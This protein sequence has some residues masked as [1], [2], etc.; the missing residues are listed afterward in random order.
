MHRP[1]PHPYV[2]IEPFVLPLRENAPYGTPPKSTAPGEREHSS[3]FIKFRDDAGYN[4]LKELTGFNKWYETDAVLNPSKGLLRDPYNKKYVRDQD[5]GEATL[6]L[7]YKRWVNYEELQRV[8]QKAD[9]FFFED[10]PGP[11]AQMMIPLT[12]PR[13]LLPTSPISKMVTKME[14]KNQVDLPFSLSPEQK[15]RV[16]EETTKA[17]IPRLKSDQEVMSYLETK[18]GELYDHEN[19]D[20]EYLTHLNKVDQRQPN[21]ELFTERHMTAQ[22]RRAEFWRKYLELFTYVD[23]LHTTMVRCTRAIGRVGSYA[24]LVIMGNGHGIFTYGRGKAPEREQSIRVAMLKTRRNVLFVPMHENRTP[25]YR[26]RGRFKKSEVLLVPQHR[27]VGIRAGR[28]TFTLLQAVGFKD[29]SCSLLGRRNIWNIIRAY[30]ECLKHQESYREVA[31]MRG[32]HYHLMSDPFLK[33]PPVP[34]RDEVQELEDAAAEAFRDAV[35][36][37]FKS[38]QLFETDT[39]KEMI[40]HFTERENFTKKWDRY[41]DMANVPQSVR[42]YPSFSEYLDAA[43]LLRE[44]RANEEVASEYEGFHHGPDSSSDDPYR[45]FYHSDPEEP[46]KPR[47]NRDVM[48][49]TAENNHINHDSLNALRSVGITPNTEYLTKGRAFTHP[50]T[51]NFNRDQ[52]NKLFHDEEQA[53]RDYKVDDNFTKKVTELQ[54]MSASAA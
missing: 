24:A 2:N 15:A 46:T 38:R 8:L 19:K 47:F 50:S 52:L 23:I 49:F 43:T 37:V 14:Q 17:T 33:T 9:H 3:S 41:M 21:T 36:T 31:M 53:V 20:E 25:Y 39:F 10:R 42:L 51:V 13:I 54:S 48:R 40:P 27:G 4:I 18:I 34:S 1:P 12:D 44:K 30:M 29:A 32:A 35:T 16:L 22:Q 26:I 28:L 6:P 7:R 45:Q 11:V 5:T